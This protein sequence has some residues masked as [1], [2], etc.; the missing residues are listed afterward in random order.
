M[1]RW[2]TTVAVAGFEF[3]R[4]FKPKDFIIT[5]VLFCCGGLFFAWVSSGDD[6]KAP[7]TVLGDALTLEDADHLPFNFLVSKGSTEEQLRERVRAGESGSILIVRSVDDVEFIAHDEVPRWYPELLAVVATARKVAKMRASGVPEE[8][9]AKVL[10]AGEV[11]L[12]LESPVEAAIKE[13]EQLLA[14]LCVFAMMLGIFMGNVHLF[15]GITGEKQNRVTESVM[16]AI[17][18]QTWIDGKLIG[19][20]LV[21]LYGLVTLG[22]CWFCAN[23]LYGI[24]LAKVELPI[25]VIDIPLLAGFLVLT[26]LGFLLWFAFFGAIASTI[27]DPNTSSRSVFM[28]LP[29][30]GLAVAFTGIEN[31][32]TGLFRFCSIFPLTSSAAMPVR[33]ATGSPAWWEHL[34]A[35]AL[36]VAT[37]W[38]FRRI[39]GKVFAMGMLTHGSEP[40][41]QQMWRAFRDA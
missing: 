36:L 15:T 27:D 2:R 1:S 35:I 9:L 3:R 10:A 13:Q 19:L 33:M 37:I 32:D 29:P 30:L 31:P 18:A 17:P 25:E 12:S 8:Q 6:T 4:V 22:I 20:S 28:F 5:L 11:T 34:L 24:F 23:E 7:I 16:S 21:A 40:S 38:L 26:G 39:A 41:W 14:A